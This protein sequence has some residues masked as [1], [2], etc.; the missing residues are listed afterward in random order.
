[1]GRQL[2]KRWRRRFVDTDELV[3][4]LADELAGKAK[5]GVP[6]HEEGMLES[7]TRKVKEAIHGKPEPKGVVEEVKEAAQE[8]MDQVK[9][10]VAEL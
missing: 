4:K 9:E 7:A 5:H 3:E 6:R 2:A 1:M 10:K 8:A